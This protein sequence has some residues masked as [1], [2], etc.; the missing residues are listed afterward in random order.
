[1]IVMAISG[2]LAYEWAVTLPLLAR[3]VFQGGAEIYGA[4][5]SA[6]GLGAVF[7]GLVVASSLDAD[8]RT[9]LIAGFVFGGLL[10]LTAAVPS[11]PLALVTL[12][13]VGGA[14]IALRATATSLLQLQAAPE[15]RGRTLALLGVAISGST[16]VG[17]PLVGWIG[18]VAGARAA[19]VVGGVATIIAAGLVGPYVSRRAARLRTDERP[20]AVPGDRV[21]SVRTGPQ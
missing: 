11:L 5:F 12:F 2:M 20:L 9:L 15:F 8:L 13:A 19:L 6:M 4:M 14:S 10:L 18:E 3:D 16:V 17:G 7:G 21:A 1:L